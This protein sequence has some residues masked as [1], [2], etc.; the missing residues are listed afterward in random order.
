MIRNIENEPFAEANNRAAA[1]AKGE[2]LLFMNNDVEPIAPGWLG[3]LVDSLEE[4]GAVAVGARM[5]YPRRVMDDNAGDSRFPDLTL[6]HRGIAM[7]AADGVPTGKN[8][9]T[10][11]DP[12]SPAA[13]LTTEV[14]GVT[15]ACL[16]VRRSAFAD[17]GG[18]TEGYVY[19]T[20]DVDLCLK[21][22]AGGG[23]I[24]YD[25]GAV[26][27]HHEYGT[28]NVHGRE[29]KKQNRVRNS[30]AVRRPLEPAGVPRGVPRSR[31]VGW[32][33]VAGTP[34][35]GDHRHKG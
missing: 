33:L 7:V 34:T 1:A 11:D 10:G 13:R 2:L 17:V 3:Q 19:G 32:A 20:E 5:V 29:W 4:H 25:G 12:L 24:I 8:L 30:T 28:Q 31:A 21:L 6:Q 9:G 23:S 14:P 16:L 15:A 26:L 35:R 27:W 18:F 22:R